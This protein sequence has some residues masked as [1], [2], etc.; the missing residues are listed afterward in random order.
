MSN[1][2]V[3]SLIAAGLAAQVTG[4]IY[5]TDPGVEAAAITATWQF[6]NIANQQVT[7]CPTG[8]S[9]VAMHSFAVDAAGRP[10]SDDVIDL[11]DC[12]DG[13]GV[14][15]PLYPDVYQTFLEVT[16]DSGTN[17]YA[18]TLSA[19]VD[20]VV[21]DKQFDATILND[22]GYF[23]LGWDLVGAVSNKPLT[24]ADVAGLDGIETV[25]TS[26]ATGSMAITDQFDCEDHFGVTGGILQ[27]AYTVSVN[28]FN[29]DGSAIGTA[30][31][32]TSKTI[33]DRNRVT[34]LG[35]IEIPIDGQ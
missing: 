14:S 19:I 21:T 8:F 4:C 27:G 15:G 35:H 3:H 23:S 1:A 24:C 22:G 7:S 25:S 33:Q 13:I 5:E 2:L 34:A 6:E 10:V 20:V 12:F 29:S 18:Q 9:T 26:M 28:A 17:V 30:P 32:I 11:F 16:N 31:A